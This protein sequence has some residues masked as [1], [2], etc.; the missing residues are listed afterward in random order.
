MPPEDWGWYK[1]NR[2]YYQILT[3]KDGAPSPLLDVIRCNCKTV[4]STKQCTCRKN[5]LDCS[6]GCGHSGVSAQISQYKLTLTV[7]M[8]SRMITEVS[9]SG[10][11][12]FY[13]EVLSLQH[14]L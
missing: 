2:K 10:N 11:K 3:D 9:E 14:Y 12:I 13:D 5:G 4:C 8:K 7:I 1:C 6:S